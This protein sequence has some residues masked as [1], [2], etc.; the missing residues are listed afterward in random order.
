MKA[1]VLKSFGFQAEPLLGARSLNA[2]TH[3]EQ[4]D[5]P[6]ALVQKWGRAGLVEPVV[7]TAMVAGGIE[8][9]THIRPRK[10]R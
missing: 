3:G 4:V 6:A 1:R 10:R 9:A 5:L 2:F 8:T 7:E